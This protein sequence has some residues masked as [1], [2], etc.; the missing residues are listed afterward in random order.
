MVREGDVVKEGE[1]RPS[2][3]YRQ[4]LYMGPTAPTAPP[5]PSPFRTG[6][7]DALGDED[8]DGAHACYI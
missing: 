3:L 8:G 7:G 4:P 1:V 2:P 6:R 5:P